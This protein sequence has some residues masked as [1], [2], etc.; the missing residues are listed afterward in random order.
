MLFCS[1]IVGAGRVLTP[2]DDLG[3]VDLGSVGEAGAGRQHRRTLAGAAAQLVL[4]VARGGSL[5]RSSALD[6][7]GLAIELAETSAG[8]PLATLSG[9]SD[10]AVFAQAE[11]WTGHRAPPQDRSRRGF[12]RFRQI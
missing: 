7:D 8:D 1:G 12:R 4:Q 11:G 3:E 6:A 10:G 9:H 2:L 5:E